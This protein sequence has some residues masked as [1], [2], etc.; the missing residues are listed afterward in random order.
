M[1]RQHAKKKSKMCATH[2]RTHYISKRENPRFEE[3]K[4]ICKKNGM[5]RFDNDNIISRILTLLLS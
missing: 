4:I 3:E 1:M 5:S 2:T